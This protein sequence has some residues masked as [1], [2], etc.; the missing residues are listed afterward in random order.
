[1]TNHDTSHILDALIA[2]KQA[3]DERPRLI[4]Q[5]EAMEGKIEALG[6]TIGNHEERI[7]R[8]KAENE[9]LTQTLRATEGARD[10]AMFRE[11]EGQDKVQSLS[12]HLQRMVQDTL[13]LLEAA[14]IGEPMALVTKASRVTEK[15][16]ADVL[17]DVSQRNLELTEA[18]QLL[19]NSLNESSDARAKLREERDRLAEDF[20]TSQAALEEARALLAHA[21]SD[22]RA[23]N[24]TTD[25]TSSNTSEGQSDSDPT[26]LSPSGS[27]SQTA[28]GPNAETSTDALPKTSAEGQSD[29]PFAPS[30]DPAPSSDAGEGVSGSVVGVERASAQPDD[31]RPKLGPQPAWSE[32]PKTSHW[33]TG[34]ARSGS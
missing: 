28:L 6:N 13:D 7:H 22:Q 15:E 9:T 5:I 30:S 4:A 29:G 3:L 16:T 31:Y 33:P 18:N 11:L 10:E 14:E 12:R 23:A 24:P 27:E 2:S 19:T 25:A 8:L 17:L 20:R 21:T 34:F 32:P 26:A 1:M